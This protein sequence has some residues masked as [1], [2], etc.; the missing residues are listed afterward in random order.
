MIKLASEIVWQKIKVSGKALFQSEEV[1]A[2]IACVKIQKI[3]KTK[4]Q[5]GVCVCDMHSL[6]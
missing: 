6:H 3:N 1:E 4:T 2:E 5:G